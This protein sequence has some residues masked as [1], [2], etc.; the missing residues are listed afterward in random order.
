MAYPKDYQQRLNNFIGKQFGLLTVMSFAYALNRSN[1]WN[2]SCK[3][4][5]T[6]IKTTG[7]LNRP[8]VSSCGC[9]HPKQLAIRS[10]T[11]GLS[12]HPLYHRFQIIKERCYNPNNRKYNYYGGR[13]IAM[14][15]EWLN[16]FQLF[17]DWCYANGY[18][19]HLHIDRINND[20]PYAP[21][22]CQFITLAENN[23]KKP[24]RVVTV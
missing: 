8:F 22:N 12:K 9:Y 7:S 11:H 13:G 4:G 17:Y 15:D 10:T 24:K 19:N 5:N 14:C 2:C 6:C 18:E 21:F 23:R 16:N 20:G 3:C 1:H